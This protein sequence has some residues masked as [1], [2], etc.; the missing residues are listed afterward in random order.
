MPKNKKI[1]SG[2]R[3]SNAS[4]SAFGWDF[5]TNAAILLMLENIQHAKSVKVEAQTEDIEIKLDNNNI[6]YSQ[7]KSHIDITSTANLM[8][9]LKESIRTLSTAYNNGDAE[10]L[11][12]I[13]NHPNPFND[14]YS[15][16]YIIGKTKLDY[17]ELPLQCKNKI[18]NIIN[19]NNYTLDTAKLKVYV[20]PFWGNDKDNR[21]K[22]IKET[23]SE[24][25]AELQI[26]T[27]YTPKKMLE[28]WQNDFFHNATIPDDKIKIKKNDIIWSLIVEVCGDLDRNDRII[29]DCDDAAIDEIERIYKT[30]ID[31][32]TED[33]LFI[34]KVLNDYLEYNKQLPLSQRTSKFINEEYVRYS[35]DFDIGNNI[36][37]YYKKC[38]IK[39]IINKIIAKRDII[40]RI[41]KGANIC[42]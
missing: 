39:L 16:Q 6:I 31:N 5:Q 4:A 17:E 33:F 18:I 7:A 40:A 41:K 37:E 28:I 19:K 42:D 11:I 20:V 1:K 27:P 38:L 24:F 22:I 10:S 36:D 13:T 9:K 25:L 23:V 8:K 35:N 26:Y 29:E 12:Y 34:N 21:D 30:I 14:K 15:T 3:T 32:K 2:S